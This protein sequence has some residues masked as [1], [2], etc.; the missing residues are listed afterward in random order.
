MLGCYLGPFSG[1]YTALFLLGVQAWFRP[2]AITNLK[3]SGRTF[4]KVLLVKAVKYPNSK[5]ILF[6]PCDGQVPAWFWSWLW[7]ML[8]PKLSWLKPDQVIYEFFFFLIYQIPRK[9]F[10]TAVININFDVNHLTLTYTLQY[11]SDW[12]CRI[13]SAKFRA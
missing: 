3:L 7:S 4:F 1:Y 13:R 10:S 8:T 5:N 2:A 9:H 12:L 6:Q 11:R